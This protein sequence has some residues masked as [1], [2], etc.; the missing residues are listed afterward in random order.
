MYILQTKIPSTN[1]GHNNELRQRKETERNLI[2]NLSRTQ[3][4]L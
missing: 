1:I 3:P 4:K 2:E